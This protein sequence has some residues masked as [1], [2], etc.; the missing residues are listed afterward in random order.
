MNK[1]NI[2][3]YGILINDRQEV[4][5]SDEREYGMEFT[6]FPG[7]GLEYGEGLREG[8]D[9]EFKEEC[10]AGIQIL[11]HVHTTDVFFKS[12][13]N[14]SQVIGVY[15]LVKNN[16]SLVCRFSKKPFDFEEGKALDQVFRW[17]PVSDLKAEDLTF[18]MDR[19]AWRVLVSEKSYG[20]E[21]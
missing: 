3:V 4:L 12:A 18:E 6:K 21:F 2:R 10:G 13:F 5:I 15:Y 20:L 16:D 7:G 11:R 14:D 9:R 8:L 17:V 1:F 19:A